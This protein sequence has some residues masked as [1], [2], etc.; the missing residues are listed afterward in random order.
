VTGESQPAIRLDD[1]LMAVNRGEGLSDPKR[2]GNTLALRVRE[3]EH[4]TIR[5][6]RL[7]PGDKFRLVLPQTGGN[8]FVEHIPQ[9]LRLVYS[10]PSGHE[11]ELLVGL[12]IYEMLAR[13]NDG[14]RPSLEEL[15]G[16]YLSLAVFKNVLASAPYQE[17]LL[18]R[19]GH[20][21]YRIRRE[22]AGTLYL[23]ALEGGAS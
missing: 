1:L 12:D 7:F 17:V 22:S 21:F 4:G 2:L 23:D 3:V 9:A 16:Y 19:T 14:Y 11:A 18:T 13:L 10:A 20:D 5:S 6:Y 8:E 15:Q